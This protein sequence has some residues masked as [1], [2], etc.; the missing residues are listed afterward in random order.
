MKY[1]SIQIC[2]KIQDIIEWYDKDWL[3]CETFRES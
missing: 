3:S 2:I 1:T